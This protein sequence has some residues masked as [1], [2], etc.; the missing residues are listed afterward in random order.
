[1]LRAL[2]SLRAEHQRALEKETERAELWIKE[3]KKS[4]ATERTQLLERIAALEEVGG[5][6]V[7]TRE[8]S[9]THGEGPGSRPITPEGHDLSG[10]TALAI[11]SAADSPR[12]PPRSETASELPHTMQAACQPLLL[13]LNLASLLLLRPR[14]ASRL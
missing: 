3:I 12:S 4:H 1:M 10:T 9:V 5:H 14:L 13:P 8:P 11:T 2:E 7:S 6:A